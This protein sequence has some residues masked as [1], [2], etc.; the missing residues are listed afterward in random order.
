MDEDAKVKKAGGVTSTSE[1]QKTMSQ[2]LKSIDRDYIE[3][4]ILEKAKKLGI[5]YINIAKSPIN[6]DLLRI[7]KPDTAKKAM[8]MPF[9]RIGKRLRIAVVDP[10]NR[11]TKQ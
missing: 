5:S 2:G 9:F 7:L 8:M 6:P 3:Q 11:E 4:A 10:E 1:P